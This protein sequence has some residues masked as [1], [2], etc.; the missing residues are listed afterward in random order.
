MVRL[1]RV[2]YRRRAI[3]W[4]LV[5]QKK[6]K[7]EGGG[8]SGHGESRLGGGSKGALLTEQEVEP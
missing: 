5:I 6:G 3:T 7:G 2:W 1:I 4:I 8:F